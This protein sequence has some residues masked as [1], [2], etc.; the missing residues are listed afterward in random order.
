MTFFGILHLPE[1][2]G[3]KTCFRPKQSE[4]S[5]TVLQDVTRFL[6]LFEREKTISRQNFVRLS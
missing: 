5:G 1:F 6:I 2:F 3:Y 4:K